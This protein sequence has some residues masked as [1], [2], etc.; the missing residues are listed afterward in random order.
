M[1]SIEIIEEIISTNNNIESFRFTRFPKQRLLQN[2]IEFNELELKHFNEAIE[3]RDKYRLPF[4]DSIMLTYFFKKET[5][6]NILKAALR[7]NS[8]I[9]NIDTSSISDIKRILKNDPF[10][11]VAFNSRVILRN[12][13]I[14]HIPLLDF[15][16]P[17]TAE[18]IIQ[19][20]KVLCLLGMNNGYIINSGES[21]HFIGNK[22]LNEDE[23][24]NFLSKSL[25]FSPIIDRA[26]I[27]H[28]LIE[29]SCSLRISLKHGIVPQL[30][31]RINE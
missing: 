12:G 11:N 9:E 15:H 6:D 7:H 14:R 8:P 23:F 5:S 13:E 16:I 27:A 17:V 21:Y 10:D 18:S 19:I 25:F 22:L 3:I 2:Q 29:R 28:Q 20:K 26:W 30:I 4:W 24:L 1:T 31:N